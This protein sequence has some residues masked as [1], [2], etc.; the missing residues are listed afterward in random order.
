[1][2]EQT[3]TQNVLI[4]DDETVVRNGIGRALER[5]GLRTRLAANGRE[6]LD[7]LDNQPFDLVL[8]DIHMP[9][10][11]G[12]QVLKEIRANHPETE[13]IMITGYPTI[14]SAVHCVKL[15]ALDYLVKPFRLDDLEAAL[16]KTSR[17]S[18]NDTIDTS[19]IDDNGMQIDSAKN[20]IIGQSRPMK[21][22]FEKILKV[23]PTDST[24]LI[25]GES[26]T[27]KELVARAIHTNSR[28]KDNEFLAIDCSSLVE[29]LLE[30]ELF[31]HVKGSFTGAAHT[32]HGFFELANHGTFFFDEI[33]NL[34]LNIQAKLLRVIQEREFM[35]VGDHKKITVD[36]RIISA[37]NKSLKES[38]KSG[39][40]RQDLYY[41][42]SVVPINL[43]PLRKRKGDIPL[44]IGHFLDQFC[45]KIKKPVPEISVEAM[46]ILKEYL[47]PGNVRELEHTMERILILEDTDVI[48]ARDLPSF[49]SQ[50][51]GEFQMFS[52]E[53]FSLEELEKKYIRFVLR[54]TKG[55]KT[56]AA[57]ILGINRKTL[58]LKIK[59]YGIN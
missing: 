58:G 2:N 54:R 37:S 24:V 18:G 46:E 48:C 7:L 30:S 22:I 13:I 55:K 9:D 45:K 53:P 33:A 28:R 34:S 52:E 20:F 49:I 50:R 31:G 29:T 25:S 17:K 5:K 16:N 57:E 4:V 12:I 27:G 43:P 6:A 59:K 36:M 32:K 19:V 41:R 47:W 8:L 40:F 42:L 44:L 38:V 3:D 11:D 10:M 23:A 56:K 15:G 39:E 1:M 21:T 51:Q 35:R 26:G 14:D